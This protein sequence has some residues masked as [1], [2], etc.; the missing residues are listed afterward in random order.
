MEFSWIYINKAAEVVCY[1]YYKFIRRYLITGSYTKLHKNLKIY[2][3]QYKIPLF[4]N[5]VMPNNHRRRNTT[6]IDITSQHLTITKQAM[7]QFKSRGCF[8]GRARRCSTIWRSA[9]RRRTPPST[10]LSCC[11]SP[12]PWPRHRPHRGEMLRNWVLEY[13]STKRVLRL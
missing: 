1:K 4:Y 12:R 3:K 6:W 9:L 2:L 7:L 5:S 10:P 8:S 13:L 11:P